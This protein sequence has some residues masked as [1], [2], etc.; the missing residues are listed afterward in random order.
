VNHHLKD[1]TKTVCTPAKLCF[2]CDLELPLAALVKAAGAIDNE[3]VSVYDGHSVRHRRPD[4]Q[5]QVDIVDIFKRNL[6]C[7]DESSK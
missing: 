6:D 4:S 7:Q 1:P 2:T 3:A 5:A